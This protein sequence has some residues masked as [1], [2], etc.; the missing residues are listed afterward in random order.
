MP[1]MRRYTAL[2]RPHRR[3]LLEAAWLVGGAWAGLR[4]FRFSVLR[5]L[6]HHCAESSPAANPAPGTEIDQVRWAIA[7]IARRFPPATCLVQAVAGDILLRRRGLASELHIGV[8]TPGKGGAHI[9]AH[10]WLECN[11]V[12]AIGDLENLA[13]FTVLTVLRP[14]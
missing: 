5:R 4:L 6:A 3:L 13:D 9:E 14:R 8:R 7:A 12:V 2:D 10:A 1:V 11:G